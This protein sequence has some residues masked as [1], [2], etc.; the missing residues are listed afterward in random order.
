MKRDNL[1]DT[2]GETVVSYIHI[3]MRRSG[4]MS[5]SG[6]VT[7]EKYALH[8]LDTAR[9]QIVSY[10]AQQKLGNRSPIIVPAYDTAVVGTP[11]EKRLLEARSEL[12][13]AADAVR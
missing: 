4:L 9:D 5:I 1:D 3:D 13:N 8:M 11:E 7:D 10:H 12:V 6:T 2:Y